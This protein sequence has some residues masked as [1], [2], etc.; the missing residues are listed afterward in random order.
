MHIYSAIMLVF[1]ANTQPIKAVNLSTL[2]DC[3]LNQKVYILRVKSHS[4]SL[5]VRR[6]ISINTKTNTHTQT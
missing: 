4:S 1:R 2:H 6:M 5:T 3:L